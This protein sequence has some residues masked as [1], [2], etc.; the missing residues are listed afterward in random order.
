MKHTHGV[1]GA[2]HPR[3]SA[4]LSSAG[5][6]NS[7]S[8]PP[9]ASRI[10]AASI[11][12]QFAMGQARMPPFLNVSSTAVLL[13]VFLT[14]LLCS[15]NSAG[16]FE[17]LQEMHLKQRQAFFSFIKHNLCKH[18]YLD[19]GTN[20][21]MQ[22]RKLYEPHLF[23]R[24]R[25]LPYYSSTF[26][27]GSRR[28]VC[29]LG[30]EPNS[31]H[32]ERLSILQ[33]SY[34]KA[35]YPTVI[36]TNAAVMNYDGHVVFYR[37]PQQKR[38][39]HESGASTIAWEGTAREVNET[40]VAVDIDLLVKAIV[41]LWHASSAFVEGQSLLIAKLDIEGGEYS[42]LPHMLAH[43]SL[44]RVDQMLIKWHSR[45]FP[46][47]SD[48]VLFAEKMVLLATQH[49]PRCRFHKVDIDDNDYADGSDRRPFPSP[50]N[51]SLVAHMVAAAASKHTHHKT[52]AT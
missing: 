32:A 52:L 12:L 9:L 21:G 15:L 49:T 26:G 10:T 42:V 34:Q 38:L 19:M 45:F 50:L 41:H 47:A 43:G 14:A 51:D 29:S 3:A 35:N 5:Q 31:L 13:V 23:P 17:R 22:F 6:R 16:D 33:A 11:R 18:I 2:G 8:P 44:C 4:S 48:S 46:N 39:Y 1:Q 36:F 20:I 27:D 40:A 7:L 30:F 28:D 37:A 25:S 24:A